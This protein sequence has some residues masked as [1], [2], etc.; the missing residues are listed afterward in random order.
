MDMCAGG[1]MAVAQGKI[2]L[3]RQGEGPELLRGIF[4]YFS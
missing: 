3:G 4:W 1:I 2:P